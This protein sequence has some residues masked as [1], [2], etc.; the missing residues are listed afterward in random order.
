MAASRHITILLLVACLAALAA[1]CGDDG[2]LAIH[3]PDDDPSATG[4]DPN[5]DPLDDPNHGEPIPREDVVLVTFDPARAIY[6]P[7]SQVNTSAELVLVDEDNEPE[8]EPEYDWSVEPEDAVSVTGNNRWSLDAEG[9]IA[10]TACTTLDEQEICGTSYILVDAGPP[11]VVLTSPEPGSIHST[12]T[13]RVAGHASDTHG[14]IHVFLYGQDLPIAEDGTFEGDYVPFYGINHIEVDATDG[15]NP[16]EGKAQLDI[17]W[18]QHYLA[19]EDPS[20]ISYDFAEAV[21]IRMGRDFFD[22]GVPY[23]PHAELLEAKTNDLAGLLEL[24]LYEADLR[25]MLPD[26]L[27]DE[28]ALYLRLQSVAIESPRVEITVLETGLEVYVQLGDIVVETDGFVSIGETQLDL[29]GQILI[30]ASA[31]ATL[32]IMK[33]PGEQLLVDVTEI[34]VTLESLESNFTSPEAD[35]IFELAESALR[36]VVDTSLV[37]TVIEGFLPSIPEAVSDLM[38]GVD[39]AL[40][41]GTVSF[42]ADPLPP[43]EFFFNGRIDAV[44]PKHHERIDIRLGAEVGTLSDPIHSEGPGVPLHAALDA[45]LELRSSGRL[46]AAVDHSLINGLLYAL[47]DS[48]LLEIDATALIPQLA[49]LADT[50]LLSAKLPP[51]LTV[52]LDR[53][54]VLTVGQLELSLESV[55]SS[56]RFAFNL[57]SSGVLVAEDNVLGLVMEDDPVLNVWLMERVGDRP[58]PLEADALGEIVMNLVWPSITETLANDLNFPLPEIDL[59]SLGEL[60]PRL[61]DLTSRVVFDSDLELRANHLIIE[62]HLEGE[63]SLAD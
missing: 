53:N 11:T 21:L 10:F 39:D 46:Q 34:E 4:E 2:R 38:G 29:K 40:S 20:S 35:A 59:S 60:A 14:E 12:D 8:Q 61:N 56:E 55:D 54:L 6:R 30:T 58:L 52:D 25:A 37:S 9:E 26:P 50:I 31:L 27:V 15:I 7:G 28:E 5:E 63:A 62:G 22:D 45:P 33:E 23:L 57:T 48:G 13:I 44:E 51:M 19:P 18:A 3:F 47:W 41:I 43:I 49:P 17:L 1:A 36:N 42:A 32:T 24:I 16:T